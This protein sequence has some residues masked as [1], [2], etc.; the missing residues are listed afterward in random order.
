MIKVN[1]YD[2]E[3]KNAHKEISD[4]FGFKIENIEIIIVENRVEYEKLL[5]RKTAEWE[6]GNSNLNKKTV[7]LLDPEQWVKEAPMHKPEE[8]SFLVKHELTHI[9]TN[10]LLNGKAI[11]MW[12]FEGLAG[13]VSGQYKKTK[14]QYFENDFCSKLDTPFNWNQQINS[15][16]YPTAYLFTSYLLNK[17]GFKTMEKLIQ[18]S[19]TYYS[20]VYFDKVV[21][22]TLGKNLS[23]LEKD[24]LENLG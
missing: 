18:S 10:H 2:M 1:K 23:E 24:F 14:I 15:G 6:V 22:N 5:G 9:Y 8:F 17:Y 11:P 20:Y 3:I 4:F 16:A 12:L 19:F 7:L 13:A 21:F